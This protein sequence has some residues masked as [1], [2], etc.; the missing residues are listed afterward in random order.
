M[1]LDKQIDYWTIS[2]NDVDVFAINQL[3]CIDRNFF[4]TKNSLR[5]LAE[6]ISYDLE[7]SISR[8]LLF[9]RMRFK[10]C[11]FFFSELNIPT[12]Q[13]IVGGRRSTGY[14][15]FYIWNLYLD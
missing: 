11:L 2:Y 14:E 1:C 6:F 8:F 5:I 3:W 12:N 7:S 13:D 4:W 15:R 9:M 10:N